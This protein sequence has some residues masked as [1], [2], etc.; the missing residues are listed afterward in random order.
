[1]KS[2]I[3]I[4]VLW[5]SQ[6]YMWTVRIDRSNLKDLNSFPSRYNEFKR[7][8]FIK[9]M[10]EHDLFLSHVDAG[11]EYSPVFYAVPMSDDCLKKVKNSLA[12]LNPD[13]IDEVMHKGRKAI[14]VWWD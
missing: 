6:I 4:E 9:W 13:E 3:A 10:K 14:R 7:S 8:A 1:M 11:R 12:K 2:A 5:A